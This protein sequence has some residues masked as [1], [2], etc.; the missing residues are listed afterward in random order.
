MMRFIFKHVPYSLLTSTLSVVLR[1]MHMYMYLQI[2]D[3]LIMLIV[4]ALVRLEERQ[5]IPMN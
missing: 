5:V 4:D 1:Y 3:I 2:Y